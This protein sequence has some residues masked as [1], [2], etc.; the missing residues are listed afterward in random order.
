MYKCEAILMDKQIFILKNH[1][2]HMKYKADNII[3][4]MFQYI[5][6][7]DLHM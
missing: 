3:Y 5:V 6:V 7:Y 1:K 4:N 2:K